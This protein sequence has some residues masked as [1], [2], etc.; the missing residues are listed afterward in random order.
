MMFTIALFGLNG[1]A[2]F[3]N[4]RHIKEEKLMKKIIALL[5]VFLLVMA[6]CSQGSSGS[7]EKESAA[8]SDPSKPLVVYLNDFDEMIGP[9]FEEKTGYKVELVSGNGAEIQSRIA[10]EK[11]NPNWDIVWMDGQAAFARWDK[12]GILLGD[13]KPENEKNLNE[14]GQSLLSKSSAYFPTGAHASSVI[15]YN[16]NEISKEKAPATWDDLAKPEFKNAVGMADPAVAAPAYPF[17]SW[18]FQD[19]GLEEGKKFFGNLFENGA[20]VY[21]KN[22]NV[23]EALL[24]GDIKVAALQESNA[25]TMKKNGEPIEIVWPKEGAPASVRYAAISKNSQNIEAAK[26][27]IEF[28]LE[29]K[30]QDEMITAGAEGYYSSSVSDVKGPSDRLENPSLLIAEPEWSAENEAVIKEWFADQSVK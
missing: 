18:F 9:L 11:G 5:S 6:G 16:T 4:R 22:P 27:F 23:V 30:T 21:P 28:L 15:V 10:A 26:A 8:K 24:N 20:K 17:V 3:C 29:K 2:L 25:Y 13:W 1:K 19:K 7:T 12:E 14:L